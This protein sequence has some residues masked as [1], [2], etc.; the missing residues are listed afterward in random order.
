MIEWLCPGCYHYNELDLRDICEDDVDPVY[1][2]VDDYCGN[3]DYLETLD[4]DW[5][6]PE[7]V[8]S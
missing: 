7:D 8:D 4:L 6:E 2:T 3:C 5:P 1:K